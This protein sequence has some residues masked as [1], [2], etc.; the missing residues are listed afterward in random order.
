MKT[1]RSIILAAFAAV[2]F[3]VLAVV[4][5]VQVVCTG[6]KALEEIQG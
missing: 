6:R 3:A 1:T 4:A 5:A 2:S